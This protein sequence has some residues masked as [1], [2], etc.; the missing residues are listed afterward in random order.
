MAMSEPDPRQEQPA[1]SRPNSDKPEVRIWV[2]SQLLGQA[3]EARIE[4]GGE[5]Y[6]LLRTRNDKLIL[7]K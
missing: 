3:H 4:H 6:R 5:V 7:V 2:S 1:S